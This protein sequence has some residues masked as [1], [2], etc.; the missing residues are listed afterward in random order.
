MFRRQSLRGKDRIHQEVDCTANE[1][2]SF[3]KLLTPGSIRTWERT[4]RN[5]RRRRTPG[6]S[7]GR[8]GSW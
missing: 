5:R 7:R 8:T 2:M 4:A 1:R 6:R 3:Q